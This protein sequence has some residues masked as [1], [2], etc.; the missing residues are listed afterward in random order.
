MTFAILEERR[1]IV[2]ILPVSKPL[3]NNWNFVYLVVATSDGFIKKCSGVTYL[4]CLT[5][6]VIR[7]INI[8][9]LNLEPTP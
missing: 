5:V 9:T 3:N 8:S 1:D 7:V 2:A 4:T 6:H